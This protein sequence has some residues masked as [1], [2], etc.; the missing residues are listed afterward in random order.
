MNTNINYPPSLSRLPRPVLFGLLAAGATL[1]TLCLLLAAI[2]ISTLPF[3]Y[4][5]PA[6]PTPITWTQLPTPTSLPSR[7]NWRSYSS[8]QSVRDT[9][10]WGDFLW[11]ATEGGLVVQDLPSGASVRFDVTHGLPANRL[12]AV[13]IGRDGRVW[14]GT[15]NSGVG[16][17][18]GAT[19]TTFGTADGLPS[20]EINDLLVD[21][22]GVVWAAT[23][24]GLARFD[25]Q[26]WQKV[27]LGLFDFSRPVVRQLA[28]SGR[29]LYAAT[30][31]GLWFFPGREWVVYTMR[32]GLPQEDVLAVA[33][34]PDEQV[35]VGTE[36]GLARFDGLSRWERFGAAEG[37][38]NAAVSLLEPRPDNSVW[39]GFEGGEIGQFDGVRHTAVSLPDERVQSITQNGSEVLVGSD[40]GLVRQTAT[41]WEGISQN[42]PQDFA[43]QELAGLVTQDTAVW[44]AGSGGLSRFDRASE[45]WATVLSADLAAV[46]T[47][48]NGRVQAAFDAPALGTISQPTDDAGAWVQVHCNREGVELGRLYAGA[49]GPDKPDGRRWFLGRTGAFAYDGERWAGYTAGLPPEPE[50]RDIAISP[51]GEVWL[52]LQQGLYLLDGATGAWRQ[53]SGTEMWRV[54]AGPDGQVW[55]AS[56]SGLV[57]VEAGGGLVQV[58]AP[59]ITAVH[60]FLATERGLWIAHSGGIAHLAADGSGWRTF[61]TADG[62]P[63]NNVTALTQD[64][65]GTVWAGFDVARL[66]FAYLPEGKTMWRIRRYDPQQ[67]DEDSPAFH[68]GSLNPRPDPVTALAVT[69]EGAVWFGTSYGRVG[70]VDAEGALLDG[71]LDPLIQWDYVN[72]LFTDDEGGLWIGSFNG[73]VVR[74][75]QGQWTVFDPD[76]ARAEVRS[77]VS[78]PQGTWLGTDVGIVFLDEAACGFETAPDRRDLVVTS[79]VAGSA[80]EVWWGSANEGA[81]RQDTAVGELSWL[82]PLRARNV[83]AVTL[84]PDSSVWFGFSG[85][86]LRY[87]PASGRAET[88]VIEHEAIETGITSLA[89]GRGARPMVGTRA[90]LL[91]PEGAGWRLLTT[92]EGLADNVVTQVV[93]DTA[94]EGAF[95]VVTPG[96]VTW[97][98][99]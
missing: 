46:T 54:A 65:Q 28:Q 53:V 24:E 81:L 91:V 41:G 9:A 23:A 3:L 92:A 8:A 83:Q 50:P 61:T 27:R 7:A 43:G 49:L 55:A 29:G 31:S 67:E 42:W 89:F 95:W 2:L 14:V 30:A 58:G 4:Q 32:D 38:P 60:D 20:N 17:Y 94:V 84:A 33:V 51:S 98:R 68:P 39:V 62:L 12:T 86:L 64:E 77:M 18:D 66:G 93:G 79:A 59:G 6:P 71:L 52:A 97:T 74:Y 47:D 45:R 11:A 96:G 90:G 5:T 10:V 36:L 69:P 88:V 37:L 34:T 99:P 40:K 19:W 22:A 87:E 56:A 82:Y 48:V 44:L 25:G 70:G 35:W 75:W 72:A 16:R 1:L 76:L 73:R 26:G 57:R 85:Q 13:E 21:G 15:A 78:T 63:S 80:G